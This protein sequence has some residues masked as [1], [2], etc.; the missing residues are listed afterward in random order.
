MLYV[1]SVS[2]T[3]FTFDAEHI[4]LLPSLVSVLSRCGEGESP[5]QSSSLL[6]SGDVQQRSAAGEGRSVLDILKHPVKSLQS[7]FLSVWENKPTVKSSTV[8]FYFTCC[9][10]LASSFTLPSLCQYLDLLLSQ[11]CAI[12][13]KHT[14]VTV[15]EACAHLASTL[16]SDRYTFS[17]RANLA[18]SQLM[19]SLTEC[20]STYLSELLQVGETVSEA[21]EQANIACSKL[22]NKMFCLRLY[23]WGWPDNEKT[24]WQNVVQFNSSQ[25]KS[26]ICWRNVISDYSKTHGSMQV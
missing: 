22:R 7:M 1:Y 8:I 21:D 19:D 3:E 23:Q 12:M 9:T 24:S 4:S 14:E 6:W 5:S 20:F 13:V 15:L 26:K 17:S 16:C 2:Y 11:I 25:Q 18:F 10:S